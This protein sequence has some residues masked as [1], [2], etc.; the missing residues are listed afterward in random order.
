VT[1]VP[2]CLAQFTRSLQILVAVPQ[3]GLQGDADVVPLTEFRFHQNVFEDGQGQ[4]L[5]LVLLHV[6]VDGYPQFLGP[7]QQ[8]ANVATDSL[9]A[10]F[11][12]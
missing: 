1:G 10:A 7:A 12:I 5:V 6:E 8:G 9:T 4:I 11:G 2:R 3:I